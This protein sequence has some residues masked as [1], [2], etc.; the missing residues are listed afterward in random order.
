MRTPSDSRTSALPV[1]LETARFPCL[2]TATPQE[3]VTIATVVEM[4]N[5][6]AL[7]PPVPHVSSRG[8]RRVWSGG[9]RRRMA[10]AMPAISGV[11]SPFIRIATA[12]API[13]AG[14]AWPSS[15]CSIAACA[16]SRVRSSRSTARPI[17]DWIIVRLPGV[18]ARASA[19][20]S[21][22]RSFAL[23]AEGEEVLD[24]TEPGARE[25]R[26]GMELHAPGLVLL[27]SQRHD[28]A[29][30]RP[31]HDLEHRRQALALDDQR[32]VARGL[33]RVV[34]P[35]EDAAPAV[36]D[37]A[38]LAVH[39]ARGAHHLAAVRLAQSL[40]PEAHPQDRHLARERQD[41][42]LADPGVARLAGPGRDH[43]PVERLRRQRLDRDRVVA[44]HLELGPQRPQ[45]LDEVVGERI[46]VVDDGDH[47]PAP[48]LP[49][50]RSARC[51]A[52]HS[53]RPLAMVSSHSRSGSE[54]AT[55][56]AP[57]PQCAAPPE[58]TSVRIAI[59][60]SRL[61]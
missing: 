42:R 24:Q 7:S 34:E 15:T 36:Q 10:S 20:A 1:R 29:L 55:M 46:V 28:L 13:C 32:V 43:E 52:S 6:P 21:S 5:V 16:R 33:E 17:A 3:A 56:P 59:A 4:L 53:A 54:S 47:P 25:H 26:L 22:R 27:V 30:G 9:T 61:P 49:I 58:Y 48:S 51:T 14:V 44:V 35:G 18:A 8:L 60:R 31:R 23:A 37:R 11:V 41:R 45:V 38:G 50:P 19:P 57:A 40:V 39:Q 2:A 12:S